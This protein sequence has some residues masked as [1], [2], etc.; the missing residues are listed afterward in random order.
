VAHRSAYQ[1]RAPEH[2]VLCSP[3]IG[4]R[5]RT[6]PGEAE[7][8]VLSACNTAGTSGRARLSP[9]VPLSGLVHAFFFAGAPALLVSHWFVEDRATQ[10]LM[11]ELFRRWAADPSV[12]RAEQLSQTMRTMLREAVVIFAEPDS[13]P[14]LGAYTLKGLVLAADV[15]NQRLVQMP[16]LLLG[17]LPPA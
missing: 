3:G 4:A 17:E 12:P 7:W 16:W 5:L 11:T 14:L 13:E 2:G 10:T 9:E 6:R 8:V 15:R 1:P